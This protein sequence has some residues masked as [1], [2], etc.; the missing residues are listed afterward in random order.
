M[1]KPV[2]SAMQDYLE[3]IGRL[4][5]E[6]GFARVRDIANRIGVTQP[7]V[8]GALR[9]LA[10]MELVNY[11]PYEVVTMTS[12]GRQLA[13][14]VR[15]RHELLSRFFTDVLG[16]PPATAESDACRVEHDLSR[17]TVERLVAFMEFIDSCPRAGAGWLERFAASCES[18]ACAGC[19]EEC[20]EK[21]RDHAEGSVES[22]TVS[23]RRGRETG[24][25]GR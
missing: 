20:M 2:S 6:R 10:E 5:D 22:T 8:T 17:E 3:A 15:R 4:A 21:L 9:N 13:R 23:G 1:V 11:K 12:Q 18:G 25:R 7:T 19:I 16:L 14:G 24:D